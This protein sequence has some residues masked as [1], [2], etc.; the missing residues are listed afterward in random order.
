MNQWL[1]INDSKWLV[2]SR[3]PPQKV[4][5]EL[6]EIVGMAQAFIFFF[7]SRI[8]C[9]SSDIHINWKKPLVQLVCSIR[10]ADLNQSRVIDVMPSCLGQ[11]LKC[12]SSPLRDWCPSQWQGPVQLCLELM[13]ELCS[14]YMRLPGI[15]VKHMC[16]IFPI[17]GFDSKR[18]TNIPL[19]AGCAVITV[20]L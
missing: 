7:S 6:N 13:W 5:K 20:V 11:W 18:I 16:N 2:K 14:K 1:V 10:F 15:P 3:E 19:K 9:T 12:K 4:V 17:F 8:I